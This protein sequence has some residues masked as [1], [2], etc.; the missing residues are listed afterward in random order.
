ME[1]I[2]PLWILTIAVMQSCDKTE[3]ISTN[4]RSSSIVCADGTPVTA[5]EE[6]GSTGSVSMDAPAL[7]AASS[8]N[9][10]EYGFSADCTGSDTFVIE[11]KDSNGT[12]TEKESTCTD[13]KL[14]AAID[15]G[16]LIDGDIILTI[17]DASKTKT[18]TQATISKD[19]TLPS[20]AITSPSADEFV[21]NTNLS[22]FPISGTCSEDD[23][24]VTITVGSTEKSTTCS[25]G[26]FSVSL[27][28]SSEAS[29]SL[30]IVS[31]HVDSIGNS[32][33]GSAASITKDTTTAL[34]VTNTNGSY[35][36]STSAA[37]Y[38]IA[39]TCSEN[40][41][42]VAISGDATASPSCS[43]GSF[44]T[45]VNLSAKADGSLSFTLRHE[46]ASGNFDEKT[47]TLTKDSSAPT[48][49]LSGTPASTMNDSAISVTVG[50]TGVVDYKYD[51]LASGAANCSTA[52]YSAS[53]PVATPISEA[54]SS[55][56]DYRL[57]VVGLDAA[58]NS[59]SVSEA[60]FT[61]D[62]TAPGA[63]DLSGLGSFTNTATPTISW[64]ASTG[65]STYDLLVDDSSDCSSPLQT[66]N[67]IAGTS[68]ALSNL[69]SDGTIYL[70]LSAKDS[71]ANTKNATT[72]PASF[73]LE[74]QAPNAPGTPNDNGVY[75]D[76]T[77]T[78]SWSNPGDNG[79]SGIASFYVQVGTSAGASDAYAGDV[80]TNT[81]YQYTGS[82]GS[83]YYIRVKAIDNAGN[84]SSYSSNSNGVMVDGV[85]P[86]GASSLSTKAD[87]VGGATATVDNDLNFYADW[88]AGSDATSGL[89]DYT[90][91]W[92]PD[93]SCSSGG[94]DITGITATDYALSGSDGTTYSFKIT[95]YDNAGNSVVSTCSG[96]ITLDTSAPP[97]LAAF[98]GATGTSSGQINLSWTY[99]GSVTDYDNIKIRREAGASAPANCSSGTL[100]T[101]ISSF[102]STSFADTGRTP[103]D[104]Y[105]YLACIYDAASNVT[106]TNTALNIQAKSYTHSIFVTD[107][108]YDGNMM[109][110]T[111]GHASAF[112]D[113]Y[114][115][116]DFRCQ[117]SAEQASLSGTWRAL[118]SFT[119]LDAKDKVAIRGPIYNMNSE[120]VASDATDLWDNSVSATLQYNET[121]ADIGYK[122]VFTGTKGTGTKET[123]YNTFCGDWTGTGGYQFYGKTTSVNAAWAYY[124]GTACSSSNP[125]YCINQYTPTL[126]GLD[127][128]TGTG[129]DGTITVSVD[130]PDDTSDYSSVKVRRL[131]G[132]EAPSRDCTTDGVEVKNYTTFTDDSFT[133][134]PGDPAGLFSYRACVYDLDNNLAYSNHYKLAVKSKG[135]FHEIFVTSTDYDGNM[136]AGTTGHAS[137][138]ADGYEG[139]D[140][141]CQYS[142]DQA[143]L[144][145]T[146][147]ALASFS[148]LD[149]KDKI[150]IRGPIYNMNSELIATDAT[151]L[152]DNSISATINYSE[153]GADVGSKIVFTAT[154][155]TGAKTTYYSFCG[156]WTTTA[157][158]QFYGRTYDVNAYWAHY[159]GTACSGTNPIYCINQYTPELTGID[160][161]TGTG[162]DGTVT[163]SVDFPADTSDYSSV[164]IRRLAG[165]EAP[166]RDCSTDGVEVK[167]YTT[168]T[169][170]SFTDSPGDPGAQ[171]S[172]RACVYDQDS[173]LA[174]SNHYKEKVK[175]KGLPHR[176]F[177]T[178]TTTTGN[179]G[180]LTGG[181]AYCQNLAD[182]AA[183]GGTWKA[184]LSSS[185]V[186]VLDRISITGPIYDINDD[187]LAADSADLWDGSIAVPIK[188]AEDG[189][190]VGTQNVFT[191]SKTDGTKETTYNSFCGDWTNTTW[192]VFYGRTTDVNG[193][194]TYYNGK[195]CTDSLHLYCIDGQ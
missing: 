167:S 143:G 24:A 55:D 19:T 82:N 97:A 149:A 122:I 11:A 48:V 87:S 148:D 47:L 10:T 89:L 156:D 41:Q 70:C 66:Y 190:D 103:N 120:L 112:T 157:G 32:G 18:I 194:W 131:A 35:V 14:T 192:Y 2:I 67:D 62:T 100:V 12:T 124:N 43:S 119:D 179:L 39:G 159:N 22:S 144:S 165:A 132:T 16:L 186:N 111:T 135:D 5:V 42:T 160:A 99:P 182:T 85:A 181:D 38:T 189:S 195:A 158:Y 175:S 31:S 8:S 171:F 4:T 96:G 177:V 185:T 21:N 20:I 138:F 101:T 163:V 13:N 77:V 72:H 125:I 93:G 49:S 84:E 30:S 40:T 154:Q 113:G 123:S 61:R 9:K 33:T 3:S 27:D 79:S 183:I 121:G 74:T 78:F 52:S 117:Y 115:G 25:S 104:Y 184:M 105:S 53:T 36:N 172:Y 164:K 98:A 170:D 80:G 180:G 108:V 174:Y 90:L 88:T 129:A 102:G 69:G 187:L 58:E 95:T 57:C 94:T 116:I 137:A 73:A 139:I 15:F 161:V 63:F 136:M 155:A 44:T 7:P 23:Q 46:A 126:T 107:S 166:S 191:G 118:V 176:I 140:F 162:A 193:Y 110:G 17:F 114:E 75:D 34:T 178:S 71:L 29:G 60:A 56:D 188:Y 68:K 45:N 76:S 128:T 6:C 130:F 153:T 141:R 142:A 1:K 150:A 152:W 26:S 168:F 83:T 151:D 91:T 147:R 64:T 109:A 146:W 145:G 65:A 169:D 127:A 81:S 133:D 86:T 106:S 59:S 37:T 50:G 173:N 28:L 51:L 134:S 92:Y 54:L